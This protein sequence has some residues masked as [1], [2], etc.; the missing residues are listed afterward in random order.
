MNTLELGRKTLIVE[1]GTKFL[2]ESLDLIDVLRIT[3][4][5]IDQII[6]DEENLR[7]FSFEYKWLE[8]LRIKAQEY[9]KRDPHGT[10]KAVESIVPYVSSFSYQEPNFS[11]F[12][13]DERNKLL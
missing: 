13:A 8:N 7:K 4:F 6:N 5:K 1:K 2:Y 11:K 12:I 10:L 3:L 9:G